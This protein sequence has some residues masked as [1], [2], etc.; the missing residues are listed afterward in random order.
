[1]EGHI[2]SFPLRV[3]SESWLCSAYFYM[4]RDLPR[5]MPH[6]NFML[7][8]FVEP[9]YRLV[10]RF[11]VSDALHAMRGRDHVGS[12]QGVDAVQRHV[13]SPPVFRRERARPHDALGRSCLSVADA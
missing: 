8:A 13:V 11:V 1:M 9:S 2:V 12:V 6:L 10:A 7:V 5:L 4:R 3:G